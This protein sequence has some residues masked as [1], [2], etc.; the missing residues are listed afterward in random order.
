[1]GHQHDRARELEQAL[2]EDLEGRDVE[3]VG[4]LVE[5]E[6]VGRPEHQASDVDAGALAARELPDRL[7]EL[8]GAEEEALRPRGHVQ[9]T[10][11]VDD[12]VAVAGEGLAERPG[13]IE[14]AA[15][16]RRS[17]RREA[18]RRG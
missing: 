13:G 1:M 18:R 15:L 2:L 3:V 10:V 17:A 12:A 9:R 8:L 4:R 7:P 5:E 11:A 6:D 14:A 16:L